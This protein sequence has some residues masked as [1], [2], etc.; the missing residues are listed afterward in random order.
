MFDMDGCEECK[1]DLAK[2]RN[3]AI[4]DASGITHHY[5]LDCY[6]RAMRKEFGKAGGII[7]R[8]KTDLG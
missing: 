2:V 4:V 5:C 6:E 7:E 1:R 8:R 3:K